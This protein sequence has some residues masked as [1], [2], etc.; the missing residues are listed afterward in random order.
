[1]LPGAAGLI[2]VALVLALAS[3]AVVF[4]KGPLL[5]LAHALG[6]ASIDRVLPEVT[7]VH[8]SGAFKILKTDAAGDAVTY[9]PCKSIHVV[10]N[11][12][13]APADFLAFILPALDAAQNAS[14]LRLVYD[15][16]TDDTWASRQ[17]VLKP[18]P[19]VIAFPER[20]EGDHV[21]ADA[22][23]LGGS[24]AVT[25]AGAVQP[26]YVTGSIALKRDWFARQS[27]EHNTGEEQAVV[28]HELGHVLG[29]DHVDDPSQLMAAYNTGQLAYGAGDLTGLAKLGAGDCAA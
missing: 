20:L 1:V 18:M 4:H 6:F 23:G 27:A 17:H 7:P 10:I 29:L 8:A 12:T 25:L 9:D 22:V 16:V 14:G 28:M 3:S 2:T 26:H 11:P 19:V 5:P 13:G 15:G 21:T 24:T